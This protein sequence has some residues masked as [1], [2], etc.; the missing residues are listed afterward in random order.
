MSAGGA[1]NIEPAER[2]GREKEWL[3]DI[4]VSASGGLKTYAPVGK[5]LSGSAILISLK[6]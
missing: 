2:K 4:Y 1:G 3:D 5:A 6:Y